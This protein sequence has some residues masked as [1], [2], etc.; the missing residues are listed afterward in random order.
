MSI[1]NPGSTQ[2]YKQMPTSEIKTFPWKKY[3]SGSPVGTKQFGNDN[4]SGLKS[5]FGV[6]VGGG[7]YYGN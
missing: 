3:V 5:G 2:F 6:W 1:S 4:I 7:F